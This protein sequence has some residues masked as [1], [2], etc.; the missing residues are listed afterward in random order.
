MADLVAQ[1]WEQVYFG[2]TDTSFFFAIV[3]VAFPVSILA[4]RS[5]LNYRQQMIRDETAYGIYKGLYDRAG[6]YP[7]P[8]QPNV[9]QSGCLTSILSFVG[10]VIAVLIVLGIAVLFIIRL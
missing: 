7:V 8:V 6:L 2:S 5:Y 4:L 10:T 1:L 3:L 9:F